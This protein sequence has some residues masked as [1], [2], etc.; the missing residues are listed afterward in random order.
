MAMDVIDMRRNGWRAREIQVLSKP[1]PQKL[2]QVRAVRGARYEMREKGT[3]GYMGLV[4]T[5]L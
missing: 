4:P 3:W 1:K 2:S 5:W